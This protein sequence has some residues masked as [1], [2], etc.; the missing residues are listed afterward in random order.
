VADL[1][2]G[3]GVI[4]LEAL[5][6]GARTCVFVDR[7]PRCVATI[8]TNL[9]RAG[10]E[11]QTRVLRADAFRAGNLLAESGPFGLIF[12]DPPY[13]LARSRRNLERIEALLAELGEPDLLADGGTVV[14]RFPSN[15]H[16]GGR[17]GALTQVDRRRYGRMRIAFFTR[18]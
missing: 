3:T 4:G 2:A 10:R 5:S 6:R 8:R 14:V 16:P 17:V 9:G 7:D 12:V 11:N 13:R 18:A 15:V 1:F